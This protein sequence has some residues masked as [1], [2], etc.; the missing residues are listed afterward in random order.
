MF[1]LSVRFGA[2]LVSSLLIV[3]TGIIAAGLWVQLARWPK[4]ISGKIEVTT[5]VAVTYYT[6]LCLSS[7]TGLAATLN[8]NSSL[9]KR[10]GFWMSC[11]T[12][13]QIAVVVVTIW[14]N[15]TTTQSNFVQMC[16]I[17]AT[18]TDTCSDLFRFGRGWIVASAVVGLLIQLIA[19]FVFYSYGNKLIEE[20]FWTQNA[21]IPQ[22]RQSMMATLASRRRSMMSAFGSKR[23]SVKPEPAAKHKYARPIRQDSRESFYSDESFDPISGYIK[24]VDNHPPFSVRF[25]PGIAYGTRGVDIIQWA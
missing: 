6:I 20:D 22:R 4:S 15:Y 18:S 24:E 10:V 8:R 14:A 3:L 5:V 9:L 11:A 1:C 17:G 12:S 23:T 13:M 16:A 2:F 25:P 19:S 7:I 21:P